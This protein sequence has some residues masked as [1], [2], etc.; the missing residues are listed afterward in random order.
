MEVCFFKL[1]GVQ[2]KGLVHVSAD[3]SMDGYAQTGY[4]TESYTTRKLS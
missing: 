4:P 2:A 1:I 3:N